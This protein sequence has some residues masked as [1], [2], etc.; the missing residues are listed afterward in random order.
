MGMQ[1]KTQVCTDLLALRSNCRA[2]IYA[3]ITKKGCAGEAPV[4][5]HNA[6]GC[7]G[8]RQR[9]RRGERVLLHTVGTRQGK[10]EE[11]VRCD[12]KLPACGK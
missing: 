7:P 5:N 6:V 10:S 9:A 3:C 11:L 1:N 2:S 8:T 4:G 12:L